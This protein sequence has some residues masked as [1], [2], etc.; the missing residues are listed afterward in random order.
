MPLP[1]IHS[2]LITAQKQVI[3][4]SSTSMAQ[5]TFPGLPQYNGYGIGLAHLTSTDLAH[6][7]VGRPALVPGAWGGP[8][9]GV[10]QPSGNATEGYYSGSATIVDAVP[11]VIIPAVFF[12]RSM[13]HSCPIKC[14]DPDPWHCMLDK[15]W[16]QKCAMVTL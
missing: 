4:T 13:A 15:E 10:G 5:A 1:C 11:R 6:W 9:G 14:A 16:V 12:N 3:H 2:N 7:R 8:I